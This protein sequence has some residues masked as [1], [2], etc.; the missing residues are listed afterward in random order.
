MGEIEMTN[1]SISDN[2]FNHLIAE[3]NRLTEVE[4]VGVDDGDG[5]HWEW[6]CARGEIFATEE[7]A[8]I[9]W[10]KRVCE[11]YENLLVE[12]LSK[13]EDEDCD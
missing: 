9:D 1:L 8:L 7:L 4:I 5:Y 13:D 3:I 12:S 6:R 11:D 10:I 2:K